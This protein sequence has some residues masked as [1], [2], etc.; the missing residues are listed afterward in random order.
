[1]H[2]FNVCSYNC[3][4]CCCCEWFFRRKILVFRPPT[5]SWLVSALESIIYLQGGRSEVIQYSSTGMNLL[6]KEH[7]RF[8]LALCVTIKLNFPSYTPRKGFTGLVLLSFQ[9]AFLAQ[10]RA[11][12][13]S[14]ELNSLV[15]TS[16]CTNSIELME[17]C[18]ALTGLFD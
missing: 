12:K 5:Q 17:F 6:I 9:I 16:P 8:F 4:C 10:L 13:P 18:V 2:K 7:L 1:M 11:A 15:E 3:C 14:N